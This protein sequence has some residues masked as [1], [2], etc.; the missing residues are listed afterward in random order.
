MAIYQLQVLITPFIECINPIYNHIKLVNGHNCGKL[1]THRS[2]HGS[3][4]PRLP[5]GPT[6]SVRNPRGG[7]HVA[8]PVAVRNVRRLWGVVGFVAGRH[9][10]GTLGI[11]MGSKR[12]R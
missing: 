6:F 1:T 10:L 7:L 5:D 11:R 3:H 9:V 4:F 2:H 8:G 12:G